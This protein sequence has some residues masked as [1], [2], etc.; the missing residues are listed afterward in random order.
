MSINSLDNLI[1]AYPRTRVGWLKNAS[2]GAAVTI[3]NFVSSWAVT[4][5]PGAGTTPGNTSTGVVPTDSTAGALTMP[6]LSGGQSMYLTDVQVNALGSQNA[7]GWLL[8]DRLW[9]AGAF[10][11]VSLSTHNITPTA[12]TRPDAN[13]MQTELWIEANATASASATTISIS[14]TNSAGTAGQTA[15]TIEDATN[16]S[17]DKIGNAHRMV[18]AAG[19]YGVQSIQSV[20][21]AGATNANGSWNVI[22]LRPVVWIMGM[23]TGYGSVGLLDPFH[24]GMPQIYANAC[25]A[26][27]AKASSTTVAVSAMIADIGLVVG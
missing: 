8:Y 25:L 18:L 4:G 14:Y 3:G 2:L 22:I 17:S 1:A 12:L 11:A 26:W 23:V 7:Y 15:S 24:C 9:H 21:F 10:T 27:M 20:T 19:D 13:G 5:M 6:V 16:L